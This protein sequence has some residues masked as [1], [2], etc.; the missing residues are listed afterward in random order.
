MPYMPHPYHS[1]M[2]TFHNKIHF[3]GELLASCPTP[4]LEVIPLP[5]VRNCLFDIFAATL[6][7]GGCSS[8]HNRRTRHAVVT[9]TH[10]SWTQTPFYIIFQI[11][12]I[13]FVCVCVCTCTRVWEGMSGW[14]FSV[15][16]QAL[17][18]SP[19]QP[20]LLFYSFLCMSIIIMEG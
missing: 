13:L 11:M 15:L 2:W 18:H 4:M 7:I 3:Y 16:G 9:G 12:K 14:A 20:S 19:L 5:A 10:L 1:S 17:C 6:H 8:I